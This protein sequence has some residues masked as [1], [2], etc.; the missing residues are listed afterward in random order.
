MNTEL[1]TELTNEQIVDMIWTAMEKELC[2]A[3]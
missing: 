2:G 1:K 3:R